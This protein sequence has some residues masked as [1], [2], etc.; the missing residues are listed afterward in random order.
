VKAA[1][2]VVGLAAMLA[3]CGASARQRAEVPV[4]GSLRLDGVTVVDTRDGQ[5]R[6]GMSILMDMGRI[7]SVTPTA[8]TP[9]DPSVH[10]VDATGEFVVPG[11]SNM[12]SHALN[13]GDPSGALALMLADG[14]TGFRQMSGSPKLLKERREGTLPIGKAA[15]AL[16]AMPGNILTPFNAGSVGDAVS[17]IRRQKQEGADFI[18]VILLSPEVFFAAI[19]EA[20]SVGLPAVG[21]LLEGVDPAQASRA[22]FRSIEHLGTGDTIWTGCSTDQPALQAE[23]AARPLAKALPFKIPFMQEIMLALSKKRLINPAA[24]ADPANVARLQRAFD[25]YSEEKCRALAMQFGANDTWQVPT[26]VRLRTQELA[27]SS[28]YRTDP[29]VGYMPPDAAKEWREVTD[30][31][32]KLPA[33][34]RETFREAYRRQ[35]ALVKLFDDVGV[36]MMTGTD[37]DG[38]V[39]GQ[40]LHQ[41]FEELARAGL[42]PLK[43]LQMTT[44]NPT[45]FLGSAATMGSVTPGKNADLVLLDANPIAGVENMRRIAGVVRAGFYYSRKDLDALRTRVGA[46]HGYLR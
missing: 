33:A 12:H 16:L 6:S 5:L 23:A 41:E 20:N 35:L 15:P 30:R 24:F 26:L 14:V 22:G 39:P 2:L 45:K 7:V 32:R 46:G 13:L 17:E 29:I 38:L 1:A 19:A 31:F 28:E 37:G 42:S 18:K 21:H 8:A 27:D 4:A 3:G 11:Y 9:K 25:T 34:M 36:P 44:L 10:S 40:S 43:V